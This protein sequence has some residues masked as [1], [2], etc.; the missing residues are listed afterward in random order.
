MR[1]AGALQRFWELHGHLAEGQHWLESLLERPESER[2]ATA[3]MLAKALKGAARLAWARG[4]GNYAAAL[5]ER[6]LQLYRAAGD[7]RGLAAVSNLLG[8]VQQAR[9]D[10]AGAMALYE[11]S[12][13][14]CRTLEDTRGIAAALNN[15]G[16]V[17]RAQG[18]YGRAG[19]LYHESLALFRR[20]SDRQSIADVLLGLGVLMA[21]QGDDAG[22][23]AYDVES[24][25]LFRSVGSQ[26]GIACCLEGIAAACARERPERAVHLF[27]AAATLRDLTGASLPP[28]DRARYEVA[29]GTTRTVLRESEWAKAW[30]EGQA[31]T[32]EQAIATA[33]DATPNG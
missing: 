9:G 23:T 22:A 29:L 2:D 1:L 26:W 11:D 7:T 16:E 14:L 10:V 18:D 17:A 25:I 8:L 20:V 21:E 15:L 33:L 32:L 27:G 12:L 24:L 19:L 5:G 6:S 31:M 30:A 3:A 13:A 4:D 28:A